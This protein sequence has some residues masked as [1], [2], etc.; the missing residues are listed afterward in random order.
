MDGDDRICHLS[1]YLLFSLQTPRQNLQMRCVAFKD[2]DN[3]DNGG[4]IC[5]RNHYG[6]SAG[7]SFFSVNNN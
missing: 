5:L 2:A 7:F 3:K 1:R 4:C 6:K